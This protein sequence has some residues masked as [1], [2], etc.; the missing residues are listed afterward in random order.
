MIWSAFMVKRGFACFHP[1]RPEIDRGQMA[2]G[3]YLILF[4]NGGGNHQDS[5][6]NK[7]SYPKKPPVLNGTAAAQIAAN[8]NPAKRPGWSTVSSSPKIWTECLNIG[9]LIIWRTA[10]API[11]E[12]KKGDPA[13]RP[14]NFS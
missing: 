14:D 1:T 8:H 13:S 6:D 2:K 4:R 9:G 5:P 11:S 7:A 12:P 3:P 10:P